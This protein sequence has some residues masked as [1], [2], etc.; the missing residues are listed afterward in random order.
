M[1]AATPMLFDGSSSAPTDA[2]NSSGLGSIIASI[3]ARGVVV[4][5][6]SSQGSMQPFGQDT[7]TA[8]DNTIMADDLVPNLPNETNMAAGASS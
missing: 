8:V 6:H 2:S 5:R 7:G 3:F 1:K 4:S